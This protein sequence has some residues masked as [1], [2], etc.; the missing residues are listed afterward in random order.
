MKFLC[1]NN[2]IRILKKEIIDGRLLFGTKLPSKRK[3]AEFLQISQNTVETAYEQLTA[4]GY[5]EVIPR[6][7]YYI[8]TFEDFE[9]TQTSQVS[10]EKSN[11]K[12]GELLYQF[13]SQPN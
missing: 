4:E 5:V 10:L 13:S 7:G 12:E 1:T 3:L 6:K 9:Y 2:Y 8:Q 11:H